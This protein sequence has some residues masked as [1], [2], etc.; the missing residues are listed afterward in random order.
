MAIICMMA[1][2]A[3][4]ESMRRQDSAVCVKPKSNT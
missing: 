4:M 2:T 3:A 1:G